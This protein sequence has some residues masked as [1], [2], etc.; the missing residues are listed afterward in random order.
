MRVCANPTETPLTDQLVVTVTD[1]KDT[2]RKIDVTIPIAIAP[3]SATG[4]D[5]DDF[6]EGDGGCCDSGRGASGSLVLA[7]IVLLAMR[8]RR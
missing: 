5:V 4:C 2:T 1:K 6:S 7:G 8:R 3:G